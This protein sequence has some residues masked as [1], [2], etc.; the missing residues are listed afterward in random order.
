MSPQT[1]APEIAFRRTLETRWSDGKYKW[2]VRMAM[3]FDRTGLHITALALAPAA[4]REVASGM[5]RA[6]LAKAMQPAPPI[7]GNL[8]RRLPLQKWVREYAATMAKEYRRIKSAPLGGTIDSLS[9][10]A[11]SSPRKSSAAF[12]ADVAKVY[13]GALESGAPTKA[14]AEH[15]KKSRT[16]AATWVYRARQLGL[17]GRTNRG[18]I[19]E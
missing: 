11:E 10:T 12:Y 5:T 15:Y 1:L 19:A 4:N 18:E 9:R 13:R 2:A 14:V 16:V 17:L 6:E 8:L 7:T 3:E